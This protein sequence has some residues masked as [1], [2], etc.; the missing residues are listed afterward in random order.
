MQNNAINAAK[1]YHLMEIDYCIKN[2]MSYKKEPEKKE[3]CLQEEQT[4]YTPIKT[5]LIK[6]DNIYM[7]RQMADKV[8]SLE[9]LKQVLLNFD[10]CEL[11][12]GAKNLVFADGKQDAKVM[13]IGEAPGA[14]ED[15]KGIPFCGVSGQ[16]LDN[17]LASIGLFREKN[18]YITNTV[19]WRPPDNRQPTTTEV[20]ICRPFVEKHI[21][22]IAPEII[23]LVGGVA[24]SSL[25]GQSEQISKVRG[26]IFKYSNPYINAIDTTAIFHPA[27]LIRQPG[28]KKTA[29]F[30]MLKLKKILKEKNIS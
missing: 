17:M 14:T 30:D 19:F 27:Y 20:E 26:Q 1:W 28:R 16:L 4:N 11:K 18:F 2:D 24:V 7:A 29:W 25:L 9:E 23:I 5:E 21:S 8:K 6:T 10:L 15:E 13:L 3:L 22:L 12:F